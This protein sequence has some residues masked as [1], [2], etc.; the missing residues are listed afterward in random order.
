MDDV[1][2]VGKQ[3]EANCNPHDYH[4]LHELMVTITLAEYRKLVEERGRLYAQI[5]HLNERIIQL[6]KAD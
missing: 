1:R 3:V 4:G 6:E 2:T 5:G